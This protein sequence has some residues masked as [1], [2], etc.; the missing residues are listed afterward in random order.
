MRPGRGLH[1]RL[2]SRTTP[3]SCVGH[4]QPC[5]PAVAVTLAAGAPK[6]E[7]VECEMNRKVD[8]WQP[9]VEQHHG[10]RS[11]GREH[12]F[13][14]IRRRAESSGH[15]A[16]LPSR[17]N[18]Q[19]A[20]CVGTAFHAGALSAG[21]GMPWHMPILV[22]TM[23]APGRVI[24]H[25]CWPAEQLAERVRVIYSN[26]CF[27]ARQIS[28]APRCRRT[29]QQQTEPARDRPA[30]PMPSASQQTASARGISRATRRMCRQ[31]SQQRT[32][33]WT[34]TSAIAERCG[35]GGGAELIVDRAA[36]RKAH[37]GRRTTLGLPSFHRC[38]RTG[39]FSTET[40]HDPTICCVLACQWAIAQRCCGTMAAC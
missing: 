10:W 36:G 1:V 8:P 4:D 27:P 5:R 3:G 32:A 39:A 30:R 20:P 29:R 22:A 2:K 18:Q 23:P 14:L 12:V 7:V 21:H 34:T 13:V 33:H 9:W 37:V 26:R 19:R 35:A 31:C 15:A 40:C 24:L 28:E 11:S 6:S 38:P 17:I 25:V 16:P